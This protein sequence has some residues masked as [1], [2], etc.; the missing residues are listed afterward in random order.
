MMASKLTKH[1]TVNAPD[2]WQGRCE[3]YWAVGLP[4][5]AGS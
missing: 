1:V 2:G 4:C 3:C 5:V